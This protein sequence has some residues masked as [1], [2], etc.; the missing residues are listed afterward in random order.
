MKN[1]ERKSYAELEELLLTKYGA[2]K[3]VPRE[4]AEYIPLTYCSPRQMRESQDPF[5]FAT[6][7][8]FYEDDEVFLLPSKGEKRYKGTCEKLGC[9]LAVSVVDG[10][11]RIW[12]TYGDDGDYRAG[13][14]FYKE[15]KTF[16]PI[17]RR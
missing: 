6:D 16:E 8:V 1:E 11:V 5:A 15:M 12:H 13:S 2:K 17:Y 4:A 7:E 14:E 3:I 9:I 10:F